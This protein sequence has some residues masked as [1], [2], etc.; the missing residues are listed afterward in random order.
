MRSNKLGKPSRPE[1]ATQRL[2][3]HLLHAVATAAITLLALPVNAAIVFP[4]N[5]LQT[6]ASIPPNIMFIL[7]N[8]GSMASVSMPDCH[9]DPEYQGTS[10]GCSG[11]LSDSADDRSYLNNTIYYDP[12]IDY[13]P[14]MTADGINR[15][16]GGQDVTAVFKDWNNA[17][18]GRGTRD[19]RDSDESIFY[20]PKKGVTNS[21]KE[22]DFERYQV[23]NVGGVAKVMRGSGDVTTLNSDSWDDRDIDELSWWR[24]TF[25]VPAGTTS[26]RFRARKG[27][28]YNSNADLY[29]RFA[30]NPTTSAYD[31]RSI[32][33]GNYEEITIDNPAAGTWH[34]GVYNSA[35]G[36]GNRYVNNEDID[37]YAYK[38][39]LVEATPTGR[40]Q[41]DELKNIATWY[42]YYRTRIKTAKAGAS[43]AFASLGR[44]YRVGYTPINGRSSHLSADGT[45]PIIPVNVN[46]GRFED[47]DSTS[48]K[49]DWFNTLQGEVVQDGSTPL[50]TS[51]NAVGQYYTRKDKNG[52]WGDG[53]N[54]AQLAC[55]PSFSILTTDGYW[56]DSTWSK[57]GLGD[58]D[59]DKNQVTLADIAHYYYN[60]D[61]RK[62]L[63]NL[64]PTS[65]ADDAE[66]QHMVTFGLSI[67]LNGNMTVTNPPPAPNSSK[68]TNPMDSEDEDRIDDL[69]HAAVNGHGT[70]VAA[71]N[72]TEF[73]K[74][75]VDA[76]SAVGNRVGSASNVTA[77]STSFQDDTAV[78]QASYTFGRWIG[79]LAAYEVDSDGIVETPLWEAS[80]KID[81]PGSRT[82][83]TWSGSTGTTFPTSAQKAELGRATGVAPVSADDNVAYIR[84]DQ[85]NEQQKG[86]TLRDRMG[87]VLGDIVDSS[88]LYV[89]DTHTIYVGA[90]DGMLH[91]FDAETGEELFAYIP[92]GIRF[93][94]TTG[95]G[96]LSDPQYVHTWFVDGPVV[97]SSLARTPGTNYL[98]GA[99]GR[100]GKGLFGLNVTAPESFGTTNVL[101]DKTGSAAPANMGQVLGEPLIVKLNDGTTGLIASNGVNSSTGT[102]SLFILSLSTGAVV[103][104][105]DTGATGDNGLSAPRGWDNDGNGTVDFVYAGDLKGNLWKFD[106]SDKS[107][108]KWD[109]ANGKKPMFVATDAS[110]NR[111]PIT[112]GLALAKDPTTGKRWVFIGT[113]KFMEDSDL[114]DD[115]IQSM[116]G[117]IDDGVVKGRTSSGDGD[118]QKRSIIQAGLSAGRPVR[119]FEPNATLASSK[120][121][122]YIDLLTPPTNTPEGERIIN[123]P[124]VSGTVL[125]TASMIPPKDEAT[126]SA[127]GRG[128]INALD[129]FSGTSTKKAYFDANGNSDFTDDL[130]GT[131]E[132]RVPIGSIDMGVGMPTLPT[133]IEDLLVVGG[134]N[135]QMGQIKIN[136]QGAGPR[137]ISW[138]E[139]LRD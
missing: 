40:E 37:V 127:G 60:T 107:S 123:R 85:S 117:V 80:K 42:S 57:F 28:G 31:A 78:Y 69:W 67:G 62:D 68:W 51:L 76:L 6:G 86:K 33:P 20:V 93:S 83:L 9:V 134:S 59:G 58:E 49:S 129:A 45:N 96:S 125:I 115:S 34:I 30:A 52:P 111:Q 112:A 70:F 94:G 39:D 104:E 126:C 5:P 18:T 77:N 131:G 130:I 138:R 100:G 109:I 72:P 32:G 116:Y 73:A 2:G 44:G 95:L 47:T 136:P 87:T 61:L 46:D 84:G 82:I 103:K 65:A 66:W 139:I 10:V 41:A 55:R 102:A 64:V 119:G 24:G 71:S 97:A 118:L 48:N 15:M 122:W 36:S 92:A 54:G 26:V 63:D 98:V 91:A 137:R 23:R 7:D 21:T 12:R 90:N 106:L 99:L 133:L 35:S 11:K 113:G 16:S 14:W 79:E 120:K 29:V 81:K 89:K 19:L 88:P 8:S 27:S 3:R 135:A 43:E 56:N 105:L 124:L 74:G 114:V 17:G 128:Y 13:K 132:N 108:S 110:N 53:T 121:G 1:S 22:S 38:I 75:L 101:W 25:V 50:R 4:D